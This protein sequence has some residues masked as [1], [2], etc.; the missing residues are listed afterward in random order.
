[1]TSV[2]G[3][4][5]QSLLSQVGKL[6]WQFSFA[7]PYHRYKKEWKIA[8]VFIGA[9][10][11]CAACGSG[12]D[13][14]PTADPKTYGSLLKQALRDLKAAAGPTFVNLVGIFDV[15]L[16]YDL[17]RGYPYCEF[18]FDK[19]P[20][21]ICGCAT[22]DEKDR[23]RVGDLAKEYNRVMRRVAYEINEENKDDGTFGVSFQP[24]LTS[25]KESSAPFGQGYMSGLDCFHPNKCANQIMAIAL[26]NNMF[27]SGL[28]KKSPKKPE[29]VKIFCP[30]PED[31]LK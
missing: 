20:I 7:G 17:S 6:K 12:E 30:G 3:A 18:L 23:K 9:N 29:D 16:V 14:P 22:G 13:I 28:K 2:S 8:T 26:W 4:V 1:M 11:L 10:N 24:G 25:F 27:A 5:V 15:S 21:P 19:N 31:Y